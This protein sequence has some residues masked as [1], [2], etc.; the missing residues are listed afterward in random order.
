MFELAMTAFGS[1]KIPSIVLQELEDITNFHN[2]Q[3][4]GDAYENKKPYNG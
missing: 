3:I 1:N 2:L 4:I